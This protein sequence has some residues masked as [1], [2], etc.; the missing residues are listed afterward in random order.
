M[1]SFRPPGRPALSLSLL[2]AALALAACQ[3]KPEEQTAGQRV[4]AGLAA[5]ERGAD[6]A[7]QETQQALQEAKNAASTT[8]DKI[9]AGLN[10]AGITASINAALAKDSELSAL[11]ID[12]DTH[13]GRVELKGQAPSRLARER[14]TQLAMAVKGVVSVDNQLRVNTQG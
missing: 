13:Q 1:T 14:A 11:K 2:L 5:A 8:V 7:K 9:E 6:K 3:P 10:D 12:V 4:D